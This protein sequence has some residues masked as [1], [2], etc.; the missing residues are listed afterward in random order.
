MDTI[1]Y[2]RAMNE[3]G[4]ITNVKGDEL[5]IVL[6]YL[7]DERISNVSYASILKSIYSMIYQYDVSLTA[8]ERASAKHILNQLDEYTRF[9]SDP[10]VVLTDDDKVCRYEEFIGKNRVVQVFPTLNRTRH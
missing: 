1:K 8:S 4:E 7:Q 2:F 10:V 9:N 3:Y 5:A 6:H